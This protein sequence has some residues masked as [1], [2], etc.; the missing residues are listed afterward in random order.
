MRSF[1]YL[2]GVVNEMTRLVLVN[3]VYFNAQWLQ[4]F[5]SDDTK[6]GKF[7]VSRNEQ[8]DVPMM[9]MKTSLGYKH[10]VPLGVRILELPYEVCSLCR[11]E[12]NTQL[13]LYYKL[14]CTV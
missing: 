8:V 2:S 12:S 11:N 3:A 9:H 14:I 1:N 5:N 6:V 13:I 4:P 7:H 10:V